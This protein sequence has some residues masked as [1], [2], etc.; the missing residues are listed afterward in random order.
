MIDQTLSFYQKLME[1]ENVVSYDVF[2]NG[3]LAYPNAPCSSEQL[4]DRLNC[5][6]QRDEGIPSSYFEYRTTRLNENDYI[7]EFNEKCGEILQYMNASE[8]PGKMVDIEEIIY[9][10]G[11][12]CRERRN[13]DCEERIKYYENSKTD[14]IHSKEVKTETSS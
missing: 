9:Y 6:I 14:Q 5:K 12:T 13:K 8:L 2:E 7:V 1:A 3:T 11:R 4:L 10:V